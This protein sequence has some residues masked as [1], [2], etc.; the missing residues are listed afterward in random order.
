MG[1]TRGSL[2]RR[3]IGAEDFEYN[4][5]NLKCVLFNVLYLVRTAIKMAAFTSK[6]SQLGPNQH[7]GICCDLNPMQNFRTLGQPLL[8][9][10]Y[11]TWKKEEL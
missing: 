3:G 2:R 11:V 9:E 5:F 1:L 4:F 6:T 7:S 8:G 10:K